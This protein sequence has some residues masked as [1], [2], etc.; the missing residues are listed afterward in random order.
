MGKKTKIGKSRQDRFYKLAKESG[1]RS[2]AAFK[3]IQLNRKFEFLQ[4]S[5]VVIDLC[6][7]PGGWLQVAAENTPISSL[8]V[9]IDLVP[10]RPIQKCITLQEDITTEKCRQAIKKELQTWKADCVLHDGSPN[11]GKNWLHDAFQQNQLT[12]QALKLA[13]EFLRKGGCFVTKIF[14]SKDYNSLLW[15]FQQLFHGVHATK[16]QASRN[17]SAEI[18]VVCE[19]FLA[20]D[21]LDPKFFDVK[22]VFEDVEKEATNS[23]NLIHPEK[24]R[25]Q[26]QG[27]PEG[28]YTLFHSLPVS[29]FLQ[30]E[31]Y[32]QLLA[33]ASEVV[34]DDDRVAQHPATTNEIK[35]CL[36]DIKVLGRKDIRGIISWRNKMKK[37]FYEEKVKV[38]VPEVEESEDD[39]AKI[40][41]KLAEVREEERKNLKKKLKKVR[42]EKIKLQHKM[43]LKMILPNDQ[44]DISDDKNLFDVGRI[45]SKR[46]LD[47]VEASN[48]DF[49]DRELADDNS[50]ESENEIDLPVKK[51]TSYDRGTKD[52]LDP[53]DASEDEYTSDVDL[54]DE[55][56]FGDEEREEEEAEANPLIITMEDKD[57]RAQRKLKTWFEKDS[58]AGLEDEEDE[59]LEIQKMAEDYRNKGGVILEKKK[60]IKESVVESDSGVGNEPKESSYEELDSESELSSD[61]DFDM[62]ELVSQKDVKQAKEKVQQ[63][64]GTETVAAD[65]LSAIPK[66]DPTGLAIGA[67]MVSS[68]KRRREIIEN[69]YHRYMFNDEGLPSW[70]V[71]EERKHMRRVLPVTKEAVQEYRE[72]LKAINARPIKKIAEAKA[73][74]KRKMMKKLEKA[75]KKSEAITD[76]QDVSEREKWQ[77][78]K[79]IYKK[80][81]LL[82]SKKKEVTYVVAKKG[83]GKKVRRP[84][85]VSGPFRVVDKRMKKD[86]M[87]VKKQSKQERHSKKRG[88]KR[89]RGKRRR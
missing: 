80:A 17:E 60:I 6:A 35:E 11:I 13:A 61:S 18:F 19:G 56:G 46:Q 65:D 67:A 47:E 7:A 88:T 74:K 58:F 41:E 55:K 76:T 75:R 83:T 20:P 37:A 34:L 9:G 44:I 30:S 79:N 43:D 50:S 57:V 73:R 84:R 29:K 25:R 59:D 2:R 26:R 38:E 15:V 33:D 36:K 4:K 78:I 22:H 16:P 85:G 31:G 42:K 40:E 28:D 32:L 82:S 64:G 12:L 24:K 86:N 45:K 52:Y 68:R 1:Y 54:S 51:V 71:Q 72:K 49:L 77:Q 81:G 69:G 5:R 10:I 53:M 21:R 23:L 14:R 62:S 3:L 87:R 27:Y 89:A 66:L 8:I 39:E 48:L 70:F 63:T